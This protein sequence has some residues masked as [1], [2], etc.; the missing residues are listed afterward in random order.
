MHLDKGQIAYDKRAV[1]YVVEFFAQLVDVADGSF[2]FKVYYKKLGA[3]GKLYIVEIFVIDLN[4]LDQLVEPD[5][6][7]R[8]TGVGT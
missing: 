5:A 4:I 8:E 3:V 7:F 6:R 1:T 2:L